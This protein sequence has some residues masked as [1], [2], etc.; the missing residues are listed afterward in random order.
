MAD[1][2]MVE[3][4]SL[5]QLLCKTAS[6]SDSAVKIEFGGTSNPNATA[7]PEVP[8]VPAAKRQ[9]L[10][11]LGGSRHQ[12][13]SDGDHT[14]LV[15][16]QPEDIIG[17]RKSSSSSYG[18][19]RIP[20]AK[21]LPSGE[22][23]ARFI[24]RAPTSISGSGGGDSSSSS[25]SSSSRR[26]SSSSSNSRGGC[27]GESGGQSV[28]GIELN[29]A[30]REWKF[31]QGAATWRS[32]PGRVTVDLLHSMPF[33]TKGRKST[34]AKEAEHQAEEVLRRADW[35]ITSATSVEEIESLVTILVK[36]LDHWSI[37]EI[38]SWCVGGS[39]AETLKTRDADGC[40]SKLVFIGC[41]QSRWVADAN[42]SKVGNTCKF[43]CRV[44]AKN[45]QFGGR[46]W[47]EVT[48]KKCTWMK[49]CYG[50]KPFGS[51]PEVP[52][53]SNC[54]AQKSS[55]RRAKPGS[56]GA[57]A[58]A[59][60]S[61]TLAPSS[62]K[63][64]APGAGTPT[65]TS[66]AL[67][68]WSICSSSSGKQLVQP[69]QPPSVPNQACSGKCGNCI[70]K[71]AQQAAAPAGLPCILFDSQFE[72]CEPCRKV[73]TKL[74]LFCRDIKIRQP[75]Q[76]FACPTAAAGG[77]GAAVVPARFRSRLRD[78]LIVV[79]GGLDLKSLAIN[80]A[81]PIILDALTSRYYS[82]QFVH[83]AEF[84]HQA[85]INLL[86]DARVDVRDALLQLLMK[87]IALGTFVFESMN[88]SAAGML[89]PDEIQLVRAVEMHTFVSCWSG[90]GGLGER[91]RSG[92]SP[93]MA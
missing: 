34:D 39:I 23:P 64:G 32:T 35:K 81:D 17:N 10:H 69:K 87:D 15:E 75:A 37:P 50:K 72:I 41:H 66:P 43:H 31:S 2:S 44:L 63:R 78:L 59:S 40:S 36:C 28:M 14:P 11:G 54:E 45:V 16:V 82:D 33:M 18:G 88:Q 24:Q 47:S 12:Q 68:E 62:R 92:N 61:P 3:A 4:T 93:P 29:L 89:A 71:L 79:F 73:L 48:L 8:A 60:P 53:C 26:R 77:A 55:L 25:S 7:L 13:E 74:E 85:D 90:S 21:A 83:Q 76:E 57:A 9:N 6:T 65:S 49:C 46:F 58:E 1:Q 22:R 84:A 38:K 86:W 67:A 70:P 51:P 56:A 30:T 20:P 5:L 80:S 91:I 52:W 27:G 19:G 42:R